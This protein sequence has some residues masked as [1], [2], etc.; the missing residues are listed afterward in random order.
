MFSCAARRK[1][2][3]W[4]RRARIK[5]E[6]E[7]AAGK[8]RADASTTAEPSPTTPGAVL[9]DGLARS[10]PWSGLHDL[11]SRSLLRRAVRDIIAVN[12]RE[13][14]LHCLNRFLLIIAG[15]LDI[16]RRSHGGA[17]RDQAQDTAEIRHF[18]AV[19]EENR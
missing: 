8:R 10:L 1:G 14:L 7:S 12:G 15:R 3:R 19:L 18:L 5:P 17:H 11:E 13:Y 4:K 16:E 6:A 9:M 2:K